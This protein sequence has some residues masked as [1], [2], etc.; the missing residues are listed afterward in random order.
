M[1]QATE[2]FD[3]FFERANE[4][5]PY[6]YQTELASGAL[7]PDVL[8]V[9]TGSG[10]TAAVLTAWLWRRRFHPDSAIRVATP[11][12]LV[13]CLP[14]RVLVEQT[15]AVARLM[16][17]RLGLAQ[18]VGVH[19]ILGGQ[20]DDAW[21]SE[22]DRDAV[23]VGTQDMLLSRALNRGYAA[24]RFRWPRLFGLLNNDALWVC[25]EIQLMG[26]GLP[27][28]VQL[29]AFRAREGTFGPT[30]T[31]FMSAT[32][33]PAW[34]RT[35]DFPA[36]ALAVQRLGTEDRMD[37]GLA[38]RLEARKSLHEVPAPTAASPRALASLILDQH[39]DESLTLVVV[40][41]VK[42]AVELYRALEKSGA[43]VLLLHSRFRPRERREA[44]RQLLAKPGSG[45]VIAVTTQVVEAGVDL[46]A[47]TLFFETAP[48][49][50][51]V[52]RLGRCNR[53]GRYEKAAV[54]WI[55]LP[56]KDARPYEA[57][58]L[59]GCRDRLRKL[60]EGADL[61]P[62]RLD[63]L[64]LDPPK[65][66]SHVLRRKDLYE[67]F[68]T[69]T[70]L[71]G[72]DVDVSRFIRDADE[73]DLLVFWRDFSG[74]PPEKFAQPE[75]DELCPAPVGVL[76]EFLEKSHA[77]A[78]V[79]DPLDETWVPVSAN[80]LRPGL[81]VLLRCEAGAYGPSIGFDVK[82]G[83][84]V[85]PVPP[86]PPSGS[87]HDAEADE[88]LDS[89]AA[90]QEPR[91]ITVREHTDDVV[92]EARELASLADGQAEAVLLA[93][94]WHDAG[95]AHPVFQRFLRKSGG[96]PPDL[97]AQYAKSPGRGGRHERPH[98]RHELA[99]AL[100]LL[101]HEPGANGDLAA[102]LVAAH[103]GKVRF[104]I[105]SLPDEFLPPQR[106]ARFA[107]GIW[108][109]ESLPPVD[110]GDDVTSPETQFDLS[111]MEIGRGPAGPSWTE[112]VLS[113]LDALGPFRLAYLEALLRAADAR[114]S[115]KEAGHA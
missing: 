115:R 24:G 10:K 74:R 22:P 43:P 11:R 66:S 2:T 81:R 38:K 92:R 17:E 77:P 106:E 80:R 34:L 93:A 13:Y 105:R 60:G 29:H 48:W 100:V 6:P 90:S 51:V 19:P 61:S 103:H 53:A 12:R 56:E 114:A 111:L 59:A 20:V 91:W 39:Q 54:H 14:M 50:S 25:D 110:L 86:V 70:D 55:D 113:L 58:E 52:Q 27:T 109:G 31:V 89:D 97:D 1:A 69:S 72:L 71:S 87:A 44:L 84:P 46:D 33:E 8:A 47:R 107:Q 7:L 67:L 49:S 73:R 37:A 15:E 9:P 28:A 102:Y 45:G 68:D 76:R 101:S 62:A 96:T 99:S 21:I 88:A 32:M 79:F 98:F 104:A 4:T 18:S 36:D 83:A 35:V 41:Q 75:R 30:S 26:C 5:I 95:K 108:E 42:R 3:R 78:W 82:T 57:A 65:P 85:E 63:E 64:P 40:N 112:R 94:R 23:I 16:L